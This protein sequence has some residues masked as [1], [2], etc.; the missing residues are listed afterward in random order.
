MPCLPP[1]IPRTDLPRLWCA[2][3]VNF[4]EFSVGQLALI[5]YEWKDVGYLGAE[6]PDADM[7]SSDLPVSSRK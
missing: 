3:S 4:A 6:T 2:R 5:V 7:G 1:P